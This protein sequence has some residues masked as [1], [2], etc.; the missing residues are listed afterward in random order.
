M[1]QRRGLVVLWLVAVV[2]AVLGL[3]LFVLPSFQ[4]PDG[5][6]RR[7]ADVAGSAVPPVA[8]QPSVRIAIAGDTGTGDAAEDATAQQMILQGQQD[9]YDALILLGDLVYENG[10]ADQ[11]NRVVTE[12]FAPLIDRGAVLIPVLGN[13]DI[14]SGEQQQILAAL[15]RQNPWYVEQIGSVRIVVLDSNQVDEP[16][17][18]QWLRETLAEPQPTGTWTLA[19]MHHPAY[20]AG[21]HGSDLSVREAWGPLFAGARV[22]LVLAGHDHDY[23]RSTPQDG[24]TYVVS[25]AGA[26]LRPTGSGDFT[27]VSAS[28]LHYLDLLV[29]D[30]RLAGRAIDQS[31]HVVDLFTITR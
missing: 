29:Y 19:A 28:T 18:T 9:P 5:K 16:A 22:P 12:P 25:G 17:Q 30:D 4:G 31:G 8:D 24:V 20:S 15:G 2:A 27:A 14:A 23:Q 10:D 13:H 1:T 6:A 26:K 21:Q 3:V 7:P 11:V